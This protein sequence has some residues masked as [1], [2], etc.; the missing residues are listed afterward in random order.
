M[1]ASQPVISVVI[2]HLNQTE[3]LRRCLQS[4]ERQSYPR[5]L[6]D[7]IVVDNGSKVLPSAIVGEYRNV[8]LEQE[9]R[10]GPGPARNRGVATSRGK[11]L[12]FIDADCIADEG[13]LASIAAAL[14]DRTSKRVV[15][16]DVRIAVAD[17]NRLTQLEAYE[18]IFAYRQ[19]EYIRKF[20]F[21]GTGNLAVRREDFDV[22]RPICR[23]RR[24]RGSRLGPQGKGAWVSRSRICRI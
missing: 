1:T 23:Y 17:P 18:S 6:F 19:E 2:P 20:G 22:D 4:L 13:W 11:I 9:A 16:G 14:S 10:P 3:S 24:G 5:E 12:A 8:S 21:S 7:V 15:G